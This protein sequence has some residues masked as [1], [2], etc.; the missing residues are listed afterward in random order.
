VICHTI[1]QFYFTDGVIYNYINRQLVL[2]CL[3]FSMACTITLA[4]HCPSLG[5]LFG[6]AAITGF[7]AGGQQIKYLENMLCFT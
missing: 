5:L 1:N 2:V 6:D 7:G 3:L 4:P